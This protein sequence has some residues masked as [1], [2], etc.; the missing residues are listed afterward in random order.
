MFFMEDMSWFKEGSVGAIFMNYFA[1]IQLLLIT[2]N[3]QL[4]TSENPNG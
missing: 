3:L 2:D 1:F 4:I